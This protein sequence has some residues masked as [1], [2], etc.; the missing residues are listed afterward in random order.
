MKPCKR[1]P[2][3]D[4]WKSYDC[5]H[6][7]KKR[8]DG[9]AVYCVDCEALRSKEYYSRSKPKRAYTSRCWTNAVRYRVVYDPLNTFTDNSEFTRP[10]IEEMCRLEYL[11]IGTEFRRGE[12]RYRITKNMKMV[13]E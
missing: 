8:R 9:Y 2:R 5:F 1:C 13:R 11:A 6:K 4:T 3:C 10:E 7:D 12:Y